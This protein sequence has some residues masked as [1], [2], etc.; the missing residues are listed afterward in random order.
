MHLPQIW[1]IMVLISFSYSVLWLTLVEANI[2]KVTYQ[3]CQI[4][5]SN[6]TSNSNCDHYLFQET[7]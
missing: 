3:D 1:E 7:I 4:Q 5:H 2:M 6:Y